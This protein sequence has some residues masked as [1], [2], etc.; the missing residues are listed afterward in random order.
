MAL[1]WISSP[2]TWTLQNVQAGLSVLVTVLSTLGIFVFVRTCWQTGVQGVARGNDVPLTSLIGLNTLGEAL[3]AVLALRSHLISYAHLH[4][5]LQVLVVVTLSVTALLSGPVSR[6]STCEAI[7]VRPQDVPGHLAKRSVS[8]VLHETNAWDKTYRRLDEAQF[9]RDQLIDYLPD[10]DIEWHFD[11]KQWNNSW[12]LDCDRTPQTNIVLESTPDCNSTRPGIFGLDEAFSFTGHDSSGYA[13]YGNNEDEAGY[14]YMYLGGMNRTDHVESEVTYRK[15]SLVLTALHMHEVEPSYNTTCPFRI[16]P[17]TECSFTKIECESLRLDTVA[18][19]SNL[20]YPDVGEREFT[21]IVRAL[22]EYYSSRH[23]REFISR[24]PISIIQPDD[25]IR[26]YQAYTIVKDTLHSQP[27]PRRLNVAGTIVQTS[28]IFLT[29]AALMTLLNLLGLANSILFARRYPRAVKA[30]PRSKIDWMIQSIQEH[31]STPASRKSGKGAYRITVP[32]E[33]AECTDREAF[34]A[35]IYGDNS[36]VL[37][38]QEAPAADTEDHGESKCALDSSGGQ[39]AG[40]TIIHN[41]VP[42]LD[43][44]AANKERAEQSRVDESKARKG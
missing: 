3:D 12:R 27:V 19:Y 24:L 36:A 6:F 20:A 41:S 10:N 43:V 32:A 13:Y 34:R 39:R 9:P 8:E 25:L 4:V 11:V 15:V 21:S 38:T 29:I 22:S 37:L 40:N 33:L 42:D 35:A 1:T 26:F 7:V 2:V 31:N 17:A 28:T 30:V 23:M 5:L 16:G 44:T 14:L 18:D